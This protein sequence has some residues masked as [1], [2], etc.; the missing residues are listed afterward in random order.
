[1]DPDEALYSAV[2]VQRPGPAWREV[3]GLSA[4]A[5]QTRFNELSG[6]GFAP[7]LVSATGPANQAIFIALFEKGVTRPWYARHNLRWDPVTDPDTITHENQRAFDQG[8]I[9]RCLAVYGIPDDRRFAGIWVKNQKSIPWAWWWSDSTTYQRF[10][11]AEVLAGVRPAYVSVAPDGWILSVFRD[12]PIGEWWARHNLTGADYQTEFD[13]RVAAG[14]MPIMVQAGGARNATRYA[15]IFAHNDEPLHWQWMTT[16]NTFSGSSHMDRTIRTFMTEHSI[17]AG[18]VAVAR[19]GHIL[20]SRGYTWAEPNYPV[21]Q[22]AT[23]FR[24]ASLSK[25][26]T[27]AAIDRLVAVG[28]LTWNTPAFDLLGISS[29]LLASQTPDS[30]VI[31][32]TIRQ[33]VLRLSGLARDFDTDLRGI[34]SKLGIITTPTRDSLVRYLYGN[35]S[36]LHPMGIHDVFV[37]A[38][39]VGSRKLHEVSSYDNPGIQLSKIDVATNKYAPNAYGGDFVLESGEG[40]GGLLTSAPSLARFIAQH[41]VWNVGKREKNLTRHGTLDGTCAGAFS[42]GDGLDVA[43]LFNRRVSENEHD[44]ITAAIKDVRLVAFLAKH[45]GFFNY[46][47]LSPMS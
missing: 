41:A 13:I 4:I 1:G 9:P 11:D 21:T 18:S 24:I 27:A 34:A 8:F 45:I 26:F 15:S 42:R 39:S 7:V 36:L 19:K 25:M 35:S 14:L 5:Y 47:R 40:V 17:R 6:Q 37:A 3:H 22:P 23:L 38:T 43:Y 29:A 10:V 12:E 30:R 20:A 2:W 46:I 33:L 32:I 28:R 16:G 44:G 31:S